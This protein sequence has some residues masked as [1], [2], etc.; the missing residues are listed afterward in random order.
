L[1]CDREASDTDEHAS[2][3]V[4]LPA[5][6]WGEILQYVE[7]PF[8][9]WVNCRRVSS[10]LRKEAQHAFRVEV[11]PL[12]HIRWLLG[13]NGTD[14]LE[15]DA[16]P[17][18][19]SVPHQD[20]LGQA[21]LEL[22]V[23]P[24]C[25][26]FAI[27]NNSAHQLNLKIM[28]ALDYKDHDFRKRQ[29]SGPYG[30]PTKY[31]VLDVSLGPGFLYST[32][33]ELPGLKLQIRVEEP[34]INSSISGSQLSPRDVGI[35]SVDWKMLMDIL[36]RDEEYIRRRTPG[37]DQTNEMRSFVLDAIKASKECLARQ[38]PELATAIQTSQCVD[39]TTEQNTF[40]MDKV[41]K[42]REKCND[43]SWQ[44]ATEHKSLYKEAYESRLK[45]CSLVADPDIKF[46]AEVPFHHQLKYDL[47]QTQCYAESIAKKR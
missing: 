10:V 20:D 29:M 25:Y 44:L 27:L 23:M 5:E 43:L 15:L 4:Y 13:T 35:I 39:F 28:Q 33:S 24:L 22:S 8:D 46:R 3:D 6:L 36:F 42:V 40:W 37:R 31:H 16:R 30:G 2:A 9:L 17:L 1:F 47:W 12:L 34:S 32:N 26:L 41:A 21:Q 14:S 38:Y 19:T 11:M 18:S 45:R 7:D